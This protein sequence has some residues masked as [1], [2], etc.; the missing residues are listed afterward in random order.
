[1]PLGRLAPHPKPSPRSCADGAALHRQTRGERGSAAVVFHE[2]CAYARSGAR[3]YM[4]AWE[5]APLAGFLLLWRRDAGSGAGEGASLTLLL[6]ALFLA[7]FCIATTEFAVVGLL[8]D[9]AADLNASIPKAGLLVSGYAI[10]VAIGGPVLTIITAPL[11]RRNAL[12]SLMAIFVVGH[13]L[14]AVSSSY[15]MLMSARIVAAVCHASFLGI[16][17]V[18]AAATAP[19]GGGARAV[20]LVW[21]GFSAASLIGVPAGT[22]LGHALG[23]RSTFWALAAI[24]SIA[25]AAVAVAVPKGG[26]TGQTNLIGEITALRRPQVLL[27][28]A[29]SLLVCAATFCV[30]AYIAPLLE[31]DTGVSARVL[32]W[33][34]F[35]FGIGGTAGLLAG[36]RLAD[37]KPLH[38]IVA[39]FLAQGV[40]YVALIF[41]VSSQVSTGAAM[42]L[43]GFLFLAPCVPL[44]ARVVKEAREGPNLASTLNQSAF[45]VGNALGPT[46]GAA[47]LSLGL[48]YHV[49][50]LLGA[51]LAAAGAAIGLV[52]IVNESR[53]PRSS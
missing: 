6:M 11:S 29:M 28:M 4:G 9:I 14:S 32:P 51:L 42:L 27:A 38:S 20:A 52:A 16:A 33:M 36:G 22:A 53:S 21:L 3:G 15:A 23:W 41:L 50:P 43:W 31:T 35:L 44:Q 25:G 13:V 8:P 26:R 45:N 34:L 49:L 5:S 1:M 24:G 2:M 30:F 37:W 46:I 10:G 17:A 48:P 18:V 19:P 12:L 47:A 7:T 39:L 40:M